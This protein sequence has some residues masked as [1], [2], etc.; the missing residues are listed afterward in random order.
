MKVSPR[1][2]FFSE[3][4][5]RISSECVDLRTKYSYWKLIPQ[6]IKLN[7]IQN[8]STTKVCILKI[9]DIKQM[10]EYTGAK[11]QIYASVDI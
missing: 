10:N 2:I 5:E 1:L 7:V 6:N 9:S 4:F 11:F 3:F 8:I